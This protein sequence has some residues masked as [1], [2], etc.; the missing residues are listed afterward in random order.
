MPFLVPV[1]QVGTINPQVER[2]INNGKYCCLPSLRKRPREH[3]LSESQYSRKC[4][5]IG[6][7]LSTL[8]M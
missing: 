5:E 6:K 4:L 7:C 1:V 8:T 3:R 2:D